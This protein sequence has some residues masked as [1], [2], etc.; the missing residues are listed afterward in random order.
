MLLNKCRAAFAHTFRV[1]LPLVAI[2]LS[3]CHGILQGEVQKGRYISQSGEF[4]I[5]LPAYHFGER[6]YRNIKAVDGT[7]GYREVVAFADHGDWFVGAGLYIVEWHRLDPGVQP[8]L[9]IT[10]VEKNF[11]AYTREHY[12]SPDKKPVEFTVAV[13]ADEELGSRPARQ[14]IARGVYGGHR[15]VMVTTAFNYGDRV[16]IVSLLYPVEMWAKKVEERWENP[17][18]AIPWNFY[19]PFAESLRRLK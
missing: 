9:Y 3:G 14:W 11:T 18:E 13:A 8:T 16:G 5:Q 6:S 17:K 12:V 1:F 19:L 4:S 7:L 10:N 15:A 2:G